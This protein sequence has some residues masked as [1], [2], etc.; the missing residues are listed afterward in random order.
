MKNFHTKKT[1]KNAAFVA[2][3]VFSSALFVTASAVYLYSPTFGS[4]ASESKDAEINLTVSSRLAIRTSA[5]ELNL[6]ANVGDF[7]HDSVNVNVSTNSQYGYTLTLEDS[8]E[9]SNMT[10]A[11]P[12]VSDVITSEFSGAKTSSQMED[13]TWGFSLDATDYFYIPVVGNP[14]AI[15]R[16]T[17]V[18]SGD[19]D[20]TTVNFGAK[21]GMTLTA[22]DY[23]DTVKF[24]AYVNGADN[25][26][27]NG[28][29][30]SEPGVTGCG[31]RATL[32]DI[33]NMQEMNTC[34]CSNTTT[35]LATS[36]I[37]DWD[38]S[39]HGDNN[40]VPR[41]KLIDTRD[42][43]DYLVSKLADGNCWMSQNLKFDLIANEPFI[44]SNNDGTTKLVTPS[45]TTQ[46]ETG[47][48]WSQT[49]DEWHSYSPHSGAAYFPG[50]SQESSAPTGPGDEYNWEKNGNYYNWY[51][52]T[53]GSGTMS[54]SYGEASSSICPSGWRLPTSFGERGFYDLI[55]M[56]YG[57]RQ[58]EESSYTGATSDPLNFIESGMYHSYTKSLDIYNGSYWA[59]DSY[60]STS[61]YILYIS[62]VSYYI[63]SYDYN[64]KYFGFAVRCV[65][66]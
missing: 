58:Y 7:V 65:A 1:D 60:S 18:V 33:S 66:I 57:L 64:T 19:Y 4:H 11:N 35:P 14:A 42:E 30:P 31:T 43:K 53:A 23:T 15:K 25:N 2:A 40:Y 22:G 29:N 37:F 49:E 61:A 12:S 13:N 44:V 55:Q 62:P 24:T 38:G 59:S 6:V 32:H 39:H 34:I 48:S 52:A 50:G 3:G 36:S 41:K 45:N 21:V 51:T 54:M 5:D 46:T 16:T 28:T 10:H 56:T 17:S 63:H 20:T 8:D 9:S 47:I 27:E 26:P